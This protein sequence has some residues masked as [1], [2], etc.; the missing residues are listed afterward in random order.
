MKALVQRV[1]RASVSVDDRIVGQI[2]AGLLIF[3]GIGRGD[4]ADDALRLARKVAELRIFADGGGKF[5]RSLIE[6]G[7]AALVVSQFTLLAD[8]RRGRRP[9]FSQAA[10]PEDAAPLISVF[11]STLR[12]RGIMVETGCFG[13]HMLVSL[14]NDGPVTILLESEAGG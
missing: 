1:T 6:T 3:I 5:N 4:G 11:A 14:E 13:A 8:T 7:G 10:A 12:E 2:A 9:S